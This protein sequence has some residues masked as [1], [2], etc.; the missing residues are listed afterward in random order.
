MP[1][2]LRSVDNPTVGLMKGGAWPSRNDS[3]GRGGWTRPPQ[4]QV[5]LRLGREQDV[6]PQGTPS[7]H[8][9]PQA[10][11]AIILGQR[12]Q[13]RGRQAGMKVGVPRSSWVGLRGGRLA[14]A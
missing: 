10:R 9:C 4:W 14:Q 2:A 11:C 6:R 12:T 3:P 13:G 8:K 5:C 1:S 7:G